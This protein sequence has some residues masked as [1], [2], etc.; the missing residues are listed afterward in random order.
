MTRLVKFHTESQGNLPENPLLFKYRYLSRNRG[1]RSGTEPE[2]ILFP[3]SKYSKFTHFP[4]SSDT[5]PLREFVPKESFTSD[6]NR[7]IESNGTVPVSCR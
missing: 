1:D 6:F 3:K 2:K 4:S 7:Q 5:T